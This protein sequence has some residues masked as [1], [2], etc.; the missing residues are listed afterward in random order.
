VPEPGAGEQ[1]DRRGIVGTDASEE[2]RRAQVVIATGRLEGTIRETVHSRPVQ[3]ASVGMLAINTKA[4]ADQGVKFP[5]D[6][7][8]DA[9][10]TYNEIAV[11]KP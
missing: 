5:D 11:P 4:A 6:V 2:P 8:K 7:T 3:K 10:Q 1:R 9:K